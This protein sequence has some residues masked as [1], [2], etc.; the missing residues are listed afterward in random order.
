M[1]GL[2]NIRFKNMG[3]KISQNT[4]MENGERQR[5][6]HRRQHLKLYRKEEEKKEGVKCAVTNHA[7]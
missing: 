4:P 5:L 1:H 2:M 6:L 7:K 3:F